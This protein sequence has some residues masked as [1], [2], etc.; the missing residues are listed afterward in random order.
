[1]CFKMLHRCCVEVYKVGRDSVSVCLYF[2]RVV[3]DS[4]LVSADASHVV[5]DTFSVRVDLRNLVL[6]FLLVLV[7]GS[8]IVVRDSV[9][10]W[11]YS[12]SY[13]SN[14]SRV[15]THALIIC[16][17]S[18]RICDYLFRDVSNS[19]VVI[20]DRL[21]VRIDSALVCFNLIFLDKNPWAKIVSNFIRGTRMK[22][23]N[24]VLRTK[25][26]LHLKKI[27]F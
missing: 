6:N 9:S 8:L 16:S 24:G 3:S 18:I 12:L 13:G 17:N 7:V 14:R 4:I 5:R 27:N 25:V 1:M 20:F 15:F 22:Y 2:W 19:N 10:V 21:L 11:S 23:I 26:D